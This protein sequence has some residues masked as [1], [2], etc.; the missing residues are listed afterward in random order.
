MFLDWLDRFGP[1]RERGPG[2]A[3]GRVPGKEPPRWAGQRRT[4]RAE[5]PD[6]LRAFRFFIGHNGVLR[7]Q[8][9][10][11]GGDAKPGREDAT[12]QEH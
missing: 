11:A 4:H 3:A 9:L 7:G 5:I 12:G 8:Q 6:F 1:G 10:S 2:G